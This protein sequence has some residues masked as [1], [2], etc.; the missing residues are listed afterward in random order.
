MLY[1]RDMCG[2]VAELGGFENR[3]LWFSKDQFCLSEF[4]GVNERDF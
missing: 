2:G 1:L 3:I 4:D